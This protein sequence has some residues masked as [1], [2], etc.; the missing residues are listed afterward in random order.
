MPSK[1]RS[2]FLDFEIE[3]QWW[4]PETPDRRVYGT[5]QYSQANGII[6]DVMDR[7]REPNLSPGVK[8]SD[9]LFNRFKIVLGQSDTLEP[10][11]LLDS[12]ETSGSLSPL[13][14]GRAR[15]RA[16]RLYIG[17]HFKTEDEIQFAQQR[18]EFAH[19]E[20]WV[21]MSPFRIEEYFEPRKT[22]VEI[23]HGPKQSSHGCLPVVPAFDRGPA[24][25]R[26]NRNFT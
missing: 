8:T 5:L 21:G 17:A 4:L 16:H 2:H 26:V 9:S 1:E 6:I 24:L 25:I 18:L 12:F 15:L 20:D 10:C 11:T 19:V 7:L 3:G 14:A 23:Q 13:G 22:V